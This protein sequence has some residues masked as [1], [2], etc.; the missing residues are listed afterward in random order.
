MCC[1]E[2]CIES[3]SIYPNSVT[4]RKGE[5]YYDIIA[6]IIPSSASCN[7]RWSSS[8]TS[9]ASVNAS[10]GYIYAQNVGSAVIYAS[11][12]DG[13]GVSACIPVTVISGNVVVESVEL[14]KNSMTVEVGATA[15][16]TAIVCP[17][18]AT[19]N[20]VIW[21]SSNSAI[22]RVDS[23]GTIYGLKRGTAIV[24]ATANDG[25]GKSDSCHVD[26][27]G[28][29]L[30][31]NV[32]L[33][34][35]C[36]TL[37]VNQSFT[38]TESILPKDATNKAV[39][40]TSSDNSVATVTSGGIVHA[41]GIGN[42]YVF[43]TARDGGGASDYCYIVVGPNVETVTLS[44]SK[45]VLLPGETADIT[46][47]IT[48]SDAADK[49]V[50]WSS[51]DSDIAS[52]RWHGKTNYRITAS[53]DVIERRTVTLTGMSVD[54]RKTVTC[55]VVVD[56]NKVEILKYGSEPVQIIFNKIDYY[57]VPYFKSWTCGDNDGNISCEFTANELAQVYRLDPD[58]VAYYVN[59]Y[60]GQF[61]DLVGRERVGRSLMLMD[62]IYEVLYGRKPYKF[63]ISDQELTQYINTIPRNWYDRYNNY[64]CAEFL[65]GVH[66]ILEDP[67]EVL[68]KASEFAIKLA[69]NLLGK[70][71]I[72]NKVFNTGANMLDCIEN[73][74][75]VCYVD[76]FQLGAKNALKLLTGKVV[77]KE[78]ENRTAQRFVLPSWV[79]T[80]VDALLD[81]KDSLDNIVR[82]HEYEY[83]ICHAMVELQR[84][85]TFKVVN[86][87]GIVEKHICITDL[88]G[89]AQLELN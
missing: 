26:V 19:N 6:E 84:E 65:F 57:N 53:S 50:V 51:T 71:E 77:E 31:T 18:N 21:S 32:M 66:N 42:A 29:V 56:P 12:T 76:S 35:R 23:D 47:I 7:V 5:W 67:L 72:I 44:H 79:G 40:W 46:C 27:T 80:V 70:C 81:I 17:S 9:V 83:T 63:D 34:Y 13:S 20:T 86:Y 52:I 15:K 28:D 62:D 2:N 89:F 3:I 55:T 30:V 10:T 14:D 74:K 49:S 85:L 88:A 69:S 73:I 8:D 4:L 41:V 1:N 54:G 45:I 11:A 78:L 48:P 25:S 58:G 37:A 16:L 24:T 61:T 38:L 82:I 43:A 87:S 33:D 60:Y 75:S 68:K 59:H 36:C 39:T 64:T 22:A